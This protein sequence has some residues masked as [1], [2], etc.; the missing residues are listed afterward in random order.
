[1]LS[2]SSQTKIL[3]I[4]EEL[5]YTALNRAWRVVAKPRTPLPQSLFS[6]CLV[7][8]SV[9]LESLPMPSFLR[10]LKWLSMTLCSLQ[11]AG[12]TLVQEVGGVR[13]ERA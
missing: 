10:D 11:K 1:M 4:I 8:I 13:M 7:M 6:S 9:C 3:A 2:S 12:A 5:I